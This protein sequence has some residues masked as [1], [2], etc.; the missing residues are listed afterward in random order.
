MMIMHPRKGVCS[1]ASYLEH[2]ARSKLSLH[3]F[4]IG[5]KL[6]VGG[7]KPCTREVGIS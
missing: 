7:W 5:F 1:V 4:S 3:R 2:F 6:Q